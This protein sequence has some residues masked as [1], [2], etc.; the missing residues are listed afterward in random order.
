[1]RYL[2]NDHDIDT[3]NFQISAAGTPL[4]VEPKVFDLLV[5]LLEN[6]PRLI[7]R[8]ELLN[9][10]W[11]GRE[12]S[13]TTLSNHIKSARKIL[14]DNGEL[15]TV[16]KTI[17]GRGY[18]FVADV[19]VHQHPVD[20]GET[21][22]TVADAPRESN[23]NVKTKRNVYLGWVLLTLAM[24][25]L[26]AWQLRSYRPGSAQPAE[27]PYVVVLPFEVS[28]EDQ[29]KWQPFADQMT[30]EVINKLSHISTLKVIPSASAFAFRQDKTH[31]H[32]ASQLPEA[33]Y[34]LDGMVSVNEQ[35]DIRVNADMTDLRSG[36]IM[37]DRIFDTHIGDADFFA[38]QTDIATA[39]ADALKIVLGK[40]EQLAIEEFPTA[41][42]A[43]Y[44]LYVEGQ[45]QMH[46]L[47][48]DSLRKSVEL[49]SQAIELD[50][51]YY[52]AYVAKADAYRIIMSYFEIP[53]DVLPDVVRTVQEALAINPNSAEALSS[54]GLAYTLAWRWQDAWRVLNA[55]KDLNPQLARTEVGFALYYS[56][57]GDAQGVHQALETANAID[58]LNIELADWGQWS[59]AMVGAIDAAVQWGRDKLRLHPDAGMLY[60]GA[61]VPAAIAGDYAGAIA[62]AQ[63]GLELDSGSPYALLALAQ[64]YGYAGQ[65]DKVRPL[66]EQAK[67]QPGYLCPYESAVT[68]ILLD[69]L[70]E[71][72][73]Q[74]NKAVAYRSNCLIFTAHDPRLMPLR[75][76]PRFDALLTRIGLDTASLSRYPR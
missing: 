73:Q 13:D 53:R 74:L 32:I 38:T 57:L 16:I 48:H 39:V 9:Q 40:N 65:V 44:E 3:E 59:L 71:A 68:Y 54:L 20:S 35:S 55:A 36:E 11:A 42:L 64:A 41:N 2:V 69:D 60:S 61:S 7:S 4:A 63:T 12:V 67:R 45:N 25:S 29:Q 22:P 37:W 33:R 6:R 66:L 26:V 1:M 17:R 47:S 31:L 52:A 76:D 43:A 10:I 24:L 14:G 8:E 21:R 46:L 62:L 75:T 72:F 19:V 70:E 28:G 30:R 51:H 27:R 56:G 18:Q 15:Q 49:F 34:V 5:Y 50:P 23:H 58:P